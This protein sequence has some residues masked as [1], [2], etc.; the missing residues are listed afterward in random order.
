[1]N[2][3]IIL[4]KTSSSLFRKKEEDFIDTVITF[5]WLELPRAWKGDKECFQTPYRIVNPPL[6]Q[7][8]HDGIYLSQE[9]PESDRMFYA[10]LKGHW[11]VYIQRWCG[12]LVLDSKSFWWAEARVN[13]IILNG[14][15]VYAALGIVHR[16]Y[17]SF[18]K[19]AIGRFLKLVWYTYVSK[20]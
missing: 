7:F 4:R 10:L 20:L 15:E 12:S 17:C 1:M 5:V 19:M 9:A 8:L 16:K 18:Q 3:I 2:K 13:Y 14:L 11:L 6:P